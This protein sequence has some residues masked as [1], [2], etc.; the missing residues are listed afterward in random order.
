[1]R[2][3]IKVARQ[4]LLLVL[5]PVS[6]LAQDRAIEIHKPRNRPATELVGIAQ[7]ALGEEGTVTVDRGTNSL[8]LIGTRASVDRAL[9][10]INAQDQARKTVILTWSSR[11]QAELAAS[12]LHV[13]WSLG[14][15]PLRIGTLRVPDNRIEISGE[16]L[17]T[18]RERKV[19]GTLRLLDGETGSI[20]SGR[21]VPVNVRDGYGRGAT[22]F[23][24]AEQGFRATP[25]V[26]GNGKVRVEIEPSDDQVNRRGETR[27]AGASTSVEVTPGDTV[28][29][30]GIG[31]RRD[32]GSRGS[33][34]LS[35]NRSGEERVFL[36]RVEVD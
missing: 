7:A 20:G 3:I 13:D 22:T 15:G 4:F 14:A 1:M 10:L 26:L 9:A 35:T 8:V 34:V 30:G 33:R 5:L 25:R 11:E 21:S 24:E 36:L 27:F 19:E 17:R 23:V 6:I 18:D 12:G 28:V 31:Q 32:E 16:I 2:I 29:L